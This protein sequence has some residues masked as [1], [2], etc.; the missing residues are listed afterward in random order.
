MP[1]TYTP[2]RYPG[3]KTK[4]YAEIQPLL[5]HAG[6]EKATYVEPFAGGAGLALKLLFCGDVKAIIL[7]D[8]D[9]NVY[10]F[11]KAC[12]ENTEKLCELVDEAE[13]S[14]KE[15]EIQ[16]SILTASS[17]HSE[18]ERAFAPLIKG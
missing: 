3:G 13:L 16:K 2:L 14:I 18:L 11:W 9:E 4:L 6:G 10:R 8:I 5:K 7:N 17:R 15:W 12:L 1:I